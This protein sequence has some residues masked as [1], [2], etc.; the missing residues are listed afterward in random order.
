MIH[1]VM[2]LF[3]AVVLLGIILLKKKTTE[4]FIDPL[5]T[6]YDPELYEGA[7]IPEANGSIL[8]PLTDYSETTIKKK[9]NKLCKNVMKQD[10]DQIDLINNY[11]IFQ[12]PKDDNS[13]YMRLDDTLVGG[14]CSTANQRMFTQDFSDTISDIRVDDMRDPYV[15]NTLRDDLCKISFK[16]GDTEKK[17]AYASFIDDNDPKVILKT[18]EMKAKQEANAKLQNE[19]N[20]LVN[21]NNGRDKTVAEQVVNIT[22]ASKQKQSKIQLSFDLSDQISDLTEDIQNF[23]F[24]SLYSK[25]KVSGSMTLQTSSDY[26]V[27]KETQAKEAGGFKTNYLDKHNITCND[28]EYISN[29]RL[30]A[31]YDP[32]RVKFK[33]QCCP[34]N[35]NMRNIPVTKQV[36]TTPWNDAGGYK[37]DFLDRHNID[38]GDN[39]LLNQVKVDTRYKPDQI[40]YTYSCVYPQFPDTARAHTICSDLKTQPNTA[41]KTANYL[42]KHSMYCPAGQGMSR[43][44]LSTDQNAKKYNYNYRCCSTIF[45]QKK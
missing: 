9:E 19:I 2:L 11:R 28:N 24:S 40:K 15:A 3:C 30:D 23:N 41:G 10:G 45:R 33:Y 21:E 20:T 6:D 18:V 42:D 26:C 43:Y 36:K 22:D 27:E 37:T 16:T 38:C 12:H 44:Q 34:V 35:P 17:I 39:G 4:Q 13:C 7:V 32:D 5:M 1:E 8:S 25:K 14:E 31:T 29:L